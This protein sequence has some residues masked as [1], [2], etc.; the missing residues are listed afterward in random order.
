MELYEITM[1]PHRLSV[2]LGLAEFRGKDLACFC[3]PE[4]PCHAQVLIREATREALHAAA[5]RKN[6]PPA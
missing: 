4:L 3:P 5:Q 1:L 2:G 6:A